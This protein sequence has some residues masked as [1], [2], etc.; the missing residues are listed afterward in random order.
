MIMK[1]LIALTLGGSAALF[2]GDKPSGVDSG[3]YQ[4][5]NRQDCLCVNAEKAIAADTQMM[6]AAVASLGDGYDKLSDDLKA[7]LRENFTDLKAAGSDK[8]TRGGTVYKRLPKA[9]GCVGLNEAP[10][11]TITYKN[12]CLTDHR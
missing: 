7:A 2:A 3:L 9:K 8:I 10:L 1:T 5:K 11:G 4:A 12:Y 6:S